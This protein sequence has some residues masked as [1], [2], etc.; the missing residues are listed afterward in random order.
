MLTYCSFLSIHQVLLGQN[1]NSYHDR[2]PMALKE[3]PELN[4]LPLSNDGFRSR[5]RRPNIGGYRFV[6]LVEAV[7]NVSPELRIRYTSPHPK[8]RILPGVDA[9][10]PNLLQLLTPIITIA[11]GLSP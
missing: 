9:M 8:V 6:D 11:T 3:R 4:I 7:A 10:S 5:I 1:V 2:S